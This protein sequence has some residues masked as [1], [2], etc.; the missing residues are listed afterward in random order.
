MSSAR[1][2][3][4]ADHVVIQALAR[5]LK[6]DIWVVTSERSKTDAGRLIEKIESGFNGDPILVG[7]VG[8]LHYISLG[9]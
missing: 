6:R 8:Q 9:K 2:G 7:H 5:M 1:N 4:W 3:E